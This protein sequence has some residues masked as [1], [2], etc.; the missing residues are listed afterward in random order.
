MLFDRTIRKAYNLDI[1]WAFQNRVSKNMPRPKG[2]KNKATIKIKTAL[3]NAFE[4]AGGEK[5][6]LKVAKNDP[7][8]FCGLLAKIVPSELHLSGTVLID[9]GQAMVEA[10]SRKKQLEA[11]R[12]PLID[13]TPIPKALKDK[14]N[15]T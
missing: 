2:S 15:S 7:K 6:L 9:I 13:V 3:T 12:P 10:D 8:T 11:T 1:T 14:D 5:Y 4:K